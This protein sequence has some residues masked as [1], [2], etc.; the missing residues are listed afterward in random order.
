[1]QVN[2][3]AY[4]R[5]G[6]AAFEQRHVEL[7]SNR[8]SRAAG[9]K[10]RVDR[11]HTANG[12]IADVGVT[13]VVIRDQI[14]SRIVTTAPKRDFVPGNFFIEAAR[15]QGEILAHREIDPAGFVGGIRRH[16]R[17]VVARRRKRGNIFASDFAQQIPRGRQF[18]FCL[19]FVG[20]GLV[21]SRLG[22]LHVGD[23]DQANLESLFRLF[24]L[25]CDCLSI[26]M[27]GCQAILGCQYVEVPRD[28]AND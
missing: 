19:N 21:V 11:R 12:Q 15:D 7:Q 9:G 20:N 6:S 26:R 1:M 22:F 4:P 24:E 27:Y 2:G 14:E 23:G 10:I 3:F 5:G 16:Q 28:H 25:S 17:K 18:P 13:V 8:F